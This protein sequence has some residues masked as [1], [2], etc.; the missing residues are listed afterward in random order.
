M[1]NEDECSKQTDTTKSIM[2]VD[3]LKSSCSIKTRIIKY[4]KTA[5][6]AVVEDNETY[7]VIKNM[8]KKK[9]MTP[10]A[11]HGSIANIILLRLRLLFHL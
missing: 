11:T 4:T 6:A 5:D 8:I 2:R 7:L 1:P 9:T 10:T 3:R